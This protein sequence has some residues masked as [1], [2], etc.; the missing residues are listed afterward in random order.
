MRVLVTGAN[1]FAGGHLCAA[2]LAR[3][4]TV[5]RAGKAHDNSDPDLLALDLLDR[6][7]VS[8]II[9]RTQPDAIAHLAAQAFVPASLADPLDT[10]DVNAGGTARLLEAV[11]AIDRSRDEKIRVLAVGSAD[12]YGPQPTGAYPLTESCAP[13]AANPYAASKIAA[14]A[15]AVAAS[16]SFGTDVVVTR[17]FNHI[18]PG[19][20]ERFAVSSF[21]RKIARIAAGADPVM[22]VGNLDAERDFSDVRDV[23]AAYTLLLEKRGDSG[24]IYNIAGGRAVSMREMLRRLVT[25][26]R[27]AVEIRNDPQLMRP[28]DIPLLLGSAE[29]LH[30][31][32][33]WTAAYSLDASLRD[34]YADAR[35]RV[36]AASGANVAGR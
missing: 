23:V 19:Q 8:S 3:G 14:E 17:A 15:F 16:R 20:D 11:R 26:S 35:E 4:H 28:S 27:T 21:A 18:G 36:A 34:I 33:G 12:V 30:A 9:E 29:K 22:Y 32:T 6:E 1:G 31:A 2:L 13:S 25:I 5:L 7:N 10:Y 24:E